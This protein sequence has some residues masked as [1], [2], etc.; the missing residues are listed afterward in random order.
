MLTKVI[1]LIVLGLTPA[2]G[3]VVVQRGGQYT[4]RAECVKAGDE[5]LA[6]AKKAGLSM[7]HLALLC[8]QTPFE[9]VAPASGQPT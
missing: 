7:E 2:D 8:L 5:F 3:K 4:D 9:S 1:V 6:E